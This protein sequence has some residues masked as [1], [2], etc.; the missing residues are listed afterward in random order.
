[1]NEE[2]ITPLEDAEMGNRGSMN[3]DRPPDS[4][5]EN[6]D[7]TKNCKGYGHLV[8]VPIL[9]ETRMLPLIDLATSLAC[10]DH[11]RVVAL[12]MATGEPEEHAFQL[13]Q[14]EPFI[15]ALEEEG[16]PVELVV[17]SSVSITRGILDATRELRAD[18]L[19]LDARIPAEGGAKLGTIAE[20]II[21]V[22]PCPVMLFRPGESESVGRIVVPIQEG[23]EAN[24]ASEL[25]IALGR[26]L[27]IPVEA[28]FLEL[29][30]PQGESEFWDEKTQM[31]A[32]SFDQSEGVHLRQSVV[33][34]EGIV[35]GFVSQ[36]QEND[37][38]VADI[39][40][41]GQWES[42]L[43]GDSSL[44]ALRRWPG[45]F[46]VNASGAVG[47]PRTTQD[48][49]WS[50]LN[51]TVTQFE[52]EELV[53]DADKS[54]YSSLDFLVLIII[55]AVLAAFGLIL[56]S[57]AVIIGAMLVAPLMTPLIALATGLVVGNI[58]I[59]RQSAFTLLQGVF[60]SLLVALLVGWI[61]ATS[62]VTAE[63]AARGNVTFLDMGVAL[64]SGV[65]GAYATARKD[66][67]SALAGVAIAAALMPPLVTIGLAIS[68]REWA[69]AQ[70]SSLLFLTNIVSITLAAWATFL[71]LGLRPGK[72]YD[73][74][75][76][77]RASRLLVVLLVVILV[78]LSVQSIDTTA[79]GRI[80]A[81]LRE[82][83]QQAELVNY[84]VRQSDP[85]EVLAVV[86]Q[87]VGNM[88]D[89]S[90]IIEAR[91]A[92]EELLD[93]PVKLSVVLEPLVDADVA[94]AN[95]A[96]QNQIDEILERTLQS[97]TLVD[98]VFLAGNPSIVFA[99]VSTDADPDT[100]PFASEI[101]AAEAAM[102]EAVSVPVELQILTAGTE[103]GVEAETSNAAFADVIEKTLKENLQNSELVE[104]T[105][106]V[107]N[108][109]IVEVTITTELES[110]SEELI[111]EIEAVEDALSDA[112]G[113]TVLLDV[114]IQGEGE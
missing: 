43:R 111:A 71:W 36:A 67:P 14:I 47:L 13:H 81:V 44:D 99:L 46:L 90:E 103:V 21:P 59:M 35:E 25:A 61:S 22:S 106:E 4:G 41:Q 72:K 40:E 20:N 55:S 3:Q 102:T 57:N 105:F 2:P 87:P 112:L 75:A 53:R 27:N 77:R 113:I 83:F 68:F 101:N 97:G 29:E 114:T 96:I 12:L 91:E 70:G 50:W 28:L 108:P 79:S 30:S 33:E 8:V 45:A 64:A 34:V 84:E 62:I 10:P 98:S 49:M 9:D 52:G 17:H 76:T 39:D 73:P 24:T 85:L 69:L 15:E 80:E 100:E 54:S 11:G 32:T 82:S 110:T 65:I 23:R 7:Q 78:A 48:K 86:R 38:A 66:I 63:M 16:Q 26:R 95:L 56:N 18:I 60:A 107:G 42:W 74:I 5:G 51:P 19:L 58:H 1:M 89:S 31:E 88:D 104:F 37:L 94:A 109:F 93:E 92:L 6:A